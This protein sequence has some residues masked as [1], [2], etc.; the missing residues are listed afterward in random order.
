MRLRPA[1][2]ED[3]ER[4]WEICRGQTA[5]E[6]CLWGA[7]LVYEYPPRL[8]QMRR[9]FEALF[10]DAV[11]FAAECGGQVVGFAEIGELDPAKKCGV[12]ARVLLEKGRRGKGRGKELVNLGLEEVKLIVYAGNLRAQRCYEACGFVRGKALLRPGRPDAWWMRVDLRG[13]SGGSQPSQRLKGV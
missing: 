1:V 5:E 7:D 8:E 2:K 11:L 12:L 9:R 13:R 6:F 3:V 4:L 10:G